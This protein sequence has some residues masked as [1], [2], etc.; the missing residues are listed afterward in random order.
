[1]KSRLFRTAPWLLLLVVSAAHTMPSAQE[2]H[3][4][5]RSALRELRAAREELQAAGDDF[6][7]HRAAALKAVDDAWRQLEQALE[8]DRR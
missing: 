6:C 8:C 3:P 4:R 2:R 1:M 7:G 5:M